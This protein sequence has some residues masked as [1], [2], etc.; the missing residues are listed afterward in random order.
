MHNVQEDKVVRAMR[1]L[2]TL[3]ARSSEQRALLL[4]DLGTPEIWGG[5]DARVL[6]LKVLPALLAEA[7]NVPLQPLSIPLVLRILA[8]KPDQVCL[9]LPHGDV[10]SFWR[11]VFH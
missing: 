8:L 5:L 2:E 1:L 4:M 9:A 10:S 7:R 11:G 3:P 6:R